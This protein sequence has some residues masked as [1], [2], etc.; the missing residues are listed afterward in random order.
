MDNL[1]DTTYSA[2]T[3]QSDASAR[4]AELTARLDARHPLEDG[5]GIDET[6]RRVEM[7]C[8]AKLSDPN[9]T[10]PL[11]YRALLQIATGDFHGFDKSLDALKR[12]NRLKLRVIPGRAV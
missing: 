1:N 4:D 11:E 7:R 6:A 10:E 8:R 9:T 12:R 2:N 5:I 3:N